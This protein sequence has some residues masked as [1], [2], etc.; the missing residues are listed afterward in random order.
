MEVAVDL[1]LSWAP[2]VC[3]VAEVRSQHLLPEVF[4][5]AKGPNL[6]EARLIGFS[7]P[8]FLL[9]LLVVPESP[10]GF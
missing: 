5:S 1:Q 6:D 10:R 9:H 8:A 2:Q 4:H 7:R 3:I